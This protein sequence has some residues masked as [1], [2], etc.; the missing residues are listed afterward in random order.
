MAVVCSSVQQTLPSQP[1]SYFNKSSLK[2][3]QLSYTAHLGGKLNCTCEIAIFKFHSL[4]S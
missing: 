4:L 1:F 2:K 3:Q